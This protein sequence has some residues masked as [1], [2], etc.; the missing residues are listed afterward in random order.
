M[1]NITAS[2][3]GADAS[4]IFGTPKDGIYTLESK[5]YTLT[6]D[7]RTEGRIYVPKGVRAIVDLNGF[8]IDRGLSSYQE[9]GGVFGVAEGASL[10][11]SDGTIKGG[12]RGSGNGGG[13]NVNGDLILNS[14]IIEN[15]KAEHAGG[16][17]Y[18]NGSDASVIMRGK[19]IVKNNTAGTYGGGIYVGENAELTIEGKPVVK[20]N[21]KSNVYLTEGRQINIFGELNP[22]TEVGITYI[23]EGKSGFTSGYSSYVNTA[24]PSEYFFGDNGDEPVINSGEARLAKEYIKRS[25][26]ST[27]KKVEEETLYADTFIP[28]SEVKV[29]ED[30][31]VDLTE[32]QWYVLTEDTLLSH[33]VRVFVGANIILCDG[34]ELT[35]KKGIVAENSNTLNIYGQKA[36]TGKLTCT[37]D[38]KCA[39]I[40]GDDDNSK[41]TVG[42]IRIFGGTVSANGGNYAAGIGGGY[43]TGNGTIEIYG[44]TVNAVCDQEKSTGIGSGENGSAGDVRIYG[45]TV[46]AKGGKY[47]AGIGC[48]NEG[49]NV[50]N[51]LIEGGKV[52]ATGTRSGAAIGGGTDGY[53]VC[54]TVTI[55]GG[56]VEA[57][58]N[59]TSACIGTGCESTYCNMDITITGGTVIAKHNTEK[60]TGGAGI[61]A[62]RSSLFKGTIT[63]TGGTVTAVGG[64]Y[65]DYT[66]PGIGGWNMEGTIT[67]TGGNV[68][69]VGINGGAAIGSATAEFGY[70]GKC[71]GTVTITGGTVRLKNE[72]SSGLTGRY[73]GSGYDVESEDDGTLTLG[74]KIKAQLRDSND[75]LIKDIPQSDR[76][77][78]CRL[79]HTD[80]NYLLLYSE[81]EPEYGDAVY[82][83]TD[84]YSSVT[85]VKK[86]LNGGDDITETVDTSYKVVAAPTESTKGIGRY[87][88]AFTNSAFAEQI[89]DVDI[90]AVVPVYDNAAYIWSDDYSSVTAVK[91]CLN[92]DADITEKVNTSF[93]VV[94]PPTTRTKGTGRYTAVF[95]NRAF[96]AQT[97]EIEIE[98]TDPSYGNATYTWADDY[99]SVTAVRKCLNGG[100]DITE[101]VNTTSAV[102]KAASYTEKG[103]TTYTAE[104]TNAAFAK[105]VKTV[106]N[107]DTIAHTPGKTVIENEISA[108][109]DSTGSYEEVIYCVDC[110]EELSRHKY[111]ISMIEKTPVTNDYETVKKDHITYQKYEKHMVVDE[112]DNQVENVVIPST[113]DGLPVTG[114]DAGA[115]YG[116]DKVKTIKI[117]EGVT[118]IGRIAFWGCKAL[119]TIDIPSTV[120]R[121]DDSI[122]DRCDSLKEVYIRS[123]NC[124][125]PM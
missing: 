60:K 76:I 64:R 61:G 101:T 120:E 34:K 90:E 42:T 113:V 27:T 75:T 119:E 41:D 79:L 53:N 122:L 99:S 97:K 57:I 49:D 51:I 15:C 125:I 38:E 47:C 109:Y 95:T 104:F 25:W 102:T 26:N 2:A 87:T 33:K 36:D 35:C 56:Y 66:A 117:P 124:S 86:C 44:G 114:I 6:E 84:D 73:L 29:S 68:T 59:Y 89:R 31:T 118:E 20:D 74:D 7:I 88:A 105:Q 4:A 39:A 93:K 12:R 5:T 81:P 110:G 69:A 83:W 116:C 14:V 43:K 67:I 65:D 37:A 78:T 82:T 22:G 9:G 115:F 70:S 108:T 94:T 85:A 1:T 48:G 71:T 18:I 45:G 58:S 50:G 11:I 100:A 121:V 24:D 16:G 63:I 13:F 32:D 19:S 92:G 123:K 107:I 80:D 8:T 112:F 111:T 91:K 30:N 17:I 3:E 40:G 106:A 62:G 46:T 28:F 52:Y 72:N 54:G 10:S 103:E 77:S 21:T 23:D 98:M 55:N 96:S